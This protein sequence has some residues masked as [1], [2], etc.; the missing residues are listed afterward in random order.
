[1]MKNNYKMQGSA[2]PNR[3]NK[4]NRWHLLLYV[5]PLFSLLLGSKNGQSQPAYNWAHSLGV[6]IA[7]TTSAIANDTSGNLYMTGS[8]GGTVDFDFGAG[9]TNLTATGTVDGFIAK[10]NPQGGLIWAKSIN[11]NA[12][13]DPWSVAVDQNE[14]VYITGYFSDTYDFD[15]SAGTANLTATGTSVD[16]FFAKYDNNGDYQWA[17]AIGDNLSDGGNC[18]AISPL[19]DIFL[20]GMFHGTM[21]FDPSAGTGILSTGAEDMFLAKYDT[22]GNYLWAKNMGGTGRNDPRSLAFDANNNVIMNGFF[23]STTDFDPSA[24]TANLTAGGRLDAF[25]AKYDNNGNYLW[26][27][28]PT[29]SGDQ[30]YNYQ[31]VVDESNSIYLCGRLDG[32]VDFD[33]SA[34][35]TNLTSSGQYDIFLVKYDE[36][37]SLMWAKS[38]GNPSTNEEAF[39]LAM[40]N[41]QQL[42]MSGY[43]EGKVDFDPSIAAADTAYLTPQ[44]ISDVFISAYDT[45]GNYLWAVDLGGAGASASSRPLIIDPTNHLYVAGSINGTVDFDPGT[46]TANASGGRKDIF[47]AKYYVCSGDTIKLNEHICG[48]TTYVLGSQLLTTAGTYTEVFTSSLC[49][50]DSVVT[51]TLAVTEVDTTVSQ[52]DATLS[53]QASGAVTY[54][55]IE[56]GVGP[57]AGE[58]GKVFTATK[59]G[60]Y[61]V[62][63]SNGSCSDTSSCYSVIGVGVNELT[64]S[65]TALQIYPNPAN[66]LV[67]IK[68]DEPTTITIFNSIGEAVYTTNLR[69]GNHPIV[70][71]YLSSGMYFIHTGNQQQYKLILQ[72]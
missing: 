63:V 22:A 25:V 12:V 42:V 69:R 72:R 16:I 47:V 55:W 46:G 23:D 60:N 53:A 24:A 8:F 36:M 38:M 39:G 65:A 70:V 29:G 50:G 66:G 31:V 51:L 64:T 33:F 9:V 62:I 61:A 37:G 56:C 27:G 40:D 44:G 52:S 68:T 3:R 30:D 59:N 7:Y 1:M 18:I 41:N 49:G 20:A 13:A 45:D 11:G 21:D 58:N 4:N 2:M 71:D 14:N 32:T 15:P 6:G 43:F 17:H 67:T 35:T 5:L 19:G 26:A 28:N 48:G 10:Y 54:Q 57:V 34:A